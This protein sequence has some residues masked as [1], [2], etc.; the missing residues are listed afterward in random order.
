MLYTENIF[1][2]FP[3]YFNLDYFYSFLIVSFI[4]YILCL[5]IIKFLFLTKTYKQKY[6]LLEVK[7]T[8]R[9]LNK[10]I[11]T[12]QLFTILHSTE[13][14]NTWYEKLIGFKKP[15]SYELLS[16]RSEGIRYLFRVP[17]QDISSIKKTLLAYLSGIEIKEVEDYAISNEFKY[18]NLG[19]KNKFIFP[20]ADQPDISHYDHL[21]Y[22][23]A[24]MTKLKE[25]EQIAIQFICSP[26]N[27]FSHQKEITF[28]K[29][30]N[31]RLKNNKILEGSHNIT[32][33]ILNNF[34]FIILSPITLISW[35][36]NDAKDPFPFWLFDE[37]NKQNKNT[38]TN[39]LYNSIEQKI[40][41]P[42]FETN[43][44]VGIH[45]IDNKE[46]Y[47][48]RIKGIASSFNTFS[49]Q[50]QTLEIKRDIFYYSSSKYIKRLSKHLFKNR[51]ALF[52]SKTILSVNELSDLY[53]FPHTET[54]KTEDLLQIKSPKLPAPISLKQ[55][56]NLFDI[57]FATN[58]Y[59]ESITPIGLTLEERR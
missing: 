29:D 8:D 26:I 27:E 39:D 38:Y 33:L 55:N 51:L 41:E 50:Y 34:L 9:N 4:L 11:S 47:N 35:L 49:T 32:N 24:Q 46:E 45:R 59:G 19:L 5:L 54:S 10:A 16:N 14:P 58:M 57:E 52:T 17:I 3:P 43:I 23:T 31:N 7:P 22:L 44:R 30:I 21:A 36:I 53:H 37:N 42:L 18:I 13:K 56:G 48:S 25:N 20:L 6:R 1:N 28:I 40:K 12:K 2:I 15:I